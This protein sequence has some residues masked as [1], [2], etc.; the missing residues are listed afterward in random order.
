MYY[1]HTTSKEPVHECSL[2]GQPCHRG[3][4]T[5]PTGW[6]RLLYLAGRGAV[7]K[8][9]LTGGTASYHSSDNTR[10]DAFE[11]H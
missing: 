4:V 6:R 10:Q 11:G 9:T 3:R 7:A 2:I 8:G 5:V 1:V